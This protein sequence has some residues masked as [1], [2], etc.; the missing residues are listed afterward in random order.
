MSL[1]CVF[2][3]ECSY[4]ECCNA[5][6]N[7]VECR[8]GRLRHNLFISKGLQVRAP[9]GRLRHNLSISKGRLID[10]QQNYNLS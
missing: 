5:E 7:F 8:K 6:R 3:A 1:C 2:N 9:K 10:F 4:A